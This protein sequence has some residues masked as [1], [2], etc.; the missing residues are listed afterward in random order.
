MIEDRSDVVGATEPPE[1][2]IEALKDPGWFAAAAYIDEVARGIFGMSALVSSV[3]DPDGFFQKQNGKP[4]GSAGVFVT[5]ES[6]RLPGMTASMLIPFELE[7]FAEV[8]IALTEMAIKLRAAE[9][10]H[11]SKAQSKLIVPEK[12]LIIPGQE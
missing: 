12:K 6:T 9:D 1:T 4:N 7:A 5:I 11:I 8:R 10:G 3:P 2:T